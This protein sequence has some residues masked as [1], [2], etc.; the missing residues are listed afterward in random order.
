MERGRSIVAAGSYGRREEE[1]E[2]REERKEQLLYNNNGKIDLNET[3]TVKAPADGHYYFEKYF[4]KSY[5]MS[6][7]DY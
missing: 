6:G 7:S 2:W 1:G 4:N 3:I 5:S